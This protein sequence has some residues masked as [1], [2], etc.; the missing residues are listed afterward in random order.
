MGRER[1]HIVA[2][3]SRVSEQGVTL[4]HAKRAAKPGDTR[5]TRSCPAQAVQPEGE[6]QRAPE[7]ENLYGLKMFLSPEGTS[8]CSSDFL[9]LSRWLA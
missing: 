9:F 6:N 8:R 4:P 1:R 7:V 5:K 3:L 2:L